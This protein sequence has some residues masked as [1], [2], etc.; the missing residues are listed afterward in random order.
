MNNQKE[1]L[2]KAIGERFANLQPEIQAVIMSTDLEKNLTKIYEKNKL[3]VEQLKNL[4][5][6]TCLILIGDT[7]P[8]DLRE[9]LDDLN[10][11]PEI[12]DQIVNDINETIL[13]PVIGMLK[14][15]FDKEDK[16]EVQYGEFV[17]QILPK[18][19]QNV[20]SQ[21]RSGFK[22]AVKSNS[23]FIND[24]KNVIGKSIIK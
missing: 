7:H 24:L 10:L 1:E 18:T 21:M 15:N 17:N 13:K 6:E 14:S 22:T 20:E 12:T 9:D 5:A 4:E 23:N 3:T 8:D 16:E 2:E 11:S 19:V